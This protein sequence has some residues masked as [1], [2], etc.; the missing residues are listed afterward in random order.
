[1]AITSVGEPAA[2]VMTTTDLG[3]RLAESAAG[4]RFEDLPAPAVDAAK[5][6]ILDTLGVI[7][8]ASGT[9]PAA[10]PVIDL[11][12]ENGGRPESSVVGF[13]FRA[14]ATSAAFANGALAHCLNFDDQTPW[15]QHSAT[16]LIPAVLAV[17]ER[18]GGVRGRDLIAAVAAGQDIFTRLRRHVGWLQDW[19]LATVLGVF[20]ATAAAGR[21]LHLSPTQ[22]SNALSIASLQ[23]SGFG[24]VVT[25]LGSQLGGIYAAFP[26][27]GA[28]TAALLAEKG[29]VGVE[30]LF[31]GRVGFLATYFAGRYDREAILAGLGRDFQG[32]TTLYK[33]WPAIGTA[34]SHIHATIR[35]VVENDLDVEEIEELRVHAGDCH[36]ILCTPP[37]A[38]RAPANLLDA[39][40]SLPFLVAVAA[41]RRGLRVSDLTGS[42]LSDPRVLAL[43]RKV[44]T[45]RDPALDWKSELPNGRVV[46][47]MR[48]GRRFDRTGTDVPGSA[49]APMTWDDLARKFA[50][51]AAAAAVPVPEGNVRAAVGMGRRL[52]SVD[53]AVDL[54]RLLTDS[55]T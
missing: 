31:E 4:V 39:R 33:P 44:V 3:R 45:V 51:C 29:T 48:D 12:R 28:V 27:R 52:E 2:E 26:A 53:D 16:S 10:R 35:A 38:R 13:G 41:V 7:L 32:A 9:E 19:N 40:F 55:G 15:G 49:R 21:L 36:E 11:V 42:A 22:M 46:I 54:V 8:A 25:G 17:A 20:S 24:E 6:T 30:T 1:M 34:H 47:R 5:K 18:Q 43:A 14:P 37:E 50:D 23:S